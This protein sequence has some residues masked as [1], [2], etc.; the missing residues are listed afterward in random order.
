VGTVAVIIERVSAVG[1]GVN[2]VDVVDVAIS[3]IIDSV[4]GDFIGVS[5]HIRC[6]VRVVVIDTCIDDESDH[7]RWTSGDIPR[8]FQRHPLACE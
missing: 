5:P 7:I 3:V 6:D 8:G 4:A 1:N 2:A